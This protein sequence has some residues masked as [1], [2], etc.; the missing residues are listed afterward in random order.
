MRDFTWSHAQKKAARL[1][2]DLAAERD[3]QA[4]LREV[5][6]MLRNSKD[7][8]VVWRIEDYLY[9]RRREH[10]RVF[11]YRYSVLIFRVCGAGAGGAAQ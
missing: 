6:G 4:I 2:F 3:T 5:E 8:R 1:A 9:E 7:P 10:D 11:D